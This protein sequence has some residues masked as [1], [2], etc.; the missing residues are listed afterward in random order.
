MVEIFMGLKEGTLKSL[1]E[2]SSGDTISIARSLFPQ[3]LQA[4]D[5]LSF[6]NIIHRDVKPANILYDSLPGG[7]YQFQL[8]DFGVSNH[9]ISATNTAG[10]PLYMAP[11]MFQKGTQTSKADVWSL[12]VTLL[13]TLDVQDFRQRSTQFKTIENVLEAVLFAASKA[14]VVSEIQEMAFLDPEKR[15]SAAHMLVKHYNGAGLSTPRTQVLALTNSPSSATA[16]AEALAPNPPALATRTTRT[17][18]RSLG[19]DVFTLGVVGQCRVEKARTPR[20]L[21]PAKRCARN[22]TKN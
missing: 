19:R 13:W 14:D 18:P 11:E 2:K 20:R 10:S 12:F 22:N 9:A 17:N 5:C 1:V 4:I 6:N 8:G 7:E 15:A 21:L 16:A 3:M